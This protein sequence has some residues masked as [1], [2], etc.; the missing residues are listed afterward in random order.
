MSRVT[1]AKTASDVGLLRAGTAVIPI[2]PPVGVAM[3]GYGLRFARGI[4]DPTFATAL[5]VRSEGVNW[6][7]VSIDAIGLDRSFTN[8]VR[9]AIRRRIGIGP[10]A[11]TVICSHTHSGPATLP[12]LNDVPADKAY[13]RFLESR[14]VE[15]AEIA[16]RHFEPV[17]WRFGMTMLPENVN[18][19]LRVGNHIELGVASA[20]PVDERLR[21]LRLDKVG[22]TS[23]PLA[24]IVHYA[25]HATTSADSLE[26]SA[27]WPGAMRNHL[28]SF[29][30]DGEGPAILFLQGCTGNLTHRIARDKDTWPEHFGRHTAVQ[31]EALGRVVASACIETSERSEQIE[32]TNIDVGVR[33]VDLPFHNGRG[34]ERSEIQIARIGPEHHLTDL[35]AKAVWF[36]GLPGEPFTEYSTDFCRAFEHHLGASFDRTLV[37]GYTNDSVGYFCTAEAL[38]EGGYEAAA[39][40]GVYHRPAPFSDKVQSLLLDRSLSAAQDLQQRP[41]EHSLSWRQA[42]T[43]LT[44]RTLRIF[45]G[46]KGAKRP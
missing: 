7:L 19:R 8:R 3:Q 30:G 42:A 26:I 10:V 12:R 18:R 4:A 37:C 17:C 9:R 24:L 13:L 2:T 29:Y 28:R 23:G 16:T 41:S 22:E 6:L 43:Q 38:R 20:S 27:D 5:A 36:V 14:L 11:I 44:G 31:S 32:A 34:S 46:L 45:S 39:A 25:C 1:S 15:A 40:H 35:R 33:R 21:V